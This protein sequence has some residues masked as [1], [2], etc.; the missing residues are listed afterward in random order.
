MLKIISALGVGLAVAFA[1]VFFGLMLGGA[2]HGWIGVIF[3]FSSVVG[4]PVATLAYVAGD[5]ASRKRRSRV[6]IWIAL[7]SD[8]LLVMTAGD[9]ALL[10]CIKWHAMILSFWF[11]GFLSWQLLAALVLWNTRDYLRITE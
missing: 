2:G 11:A 9:T 4:A 7:I 8:I 5:V 1:V 6:A 10:L 3:S